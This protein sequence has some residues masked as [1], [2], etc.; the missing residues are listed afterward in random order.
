MISQDIG[1]VTAEAIRHI[2]TTSVDGRSYA[3][4]EDLLN[5][6][7][8]SGDTLVDVYEEHLLSRTSPIENLIVSNKV[9]SMALVYSVIDSILHALEDLEGIEGLCPGDFR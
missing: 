9:E 3:S 6:I 5:Y 4:I 2:E 1:Q 8:A 7:H